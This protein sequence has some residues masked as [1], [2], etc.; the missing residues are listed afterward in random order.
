M[1][2]TTAEK[3][4]IRRYCG[5]PM[6]GGTP[7]S[8]Q[9]YRFFQAYG[10]LEYR[11]NNMLAEEEAVVRTT[12]LANL[13]TLETAIPSAS[14]NLD[15]DQAAVWVHNKREVAD[16]DA[17]FANWRRKLCEFM[18]IPPGPGLGAGGSVQL[19]V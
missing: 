15:T 3:V 11:M 9:S 19:V 5:Y 16:R 8:F 6:F 17:L 13:T 10:T 1:A 14:A 7:S 18:G 12:Y 4:D 2:F